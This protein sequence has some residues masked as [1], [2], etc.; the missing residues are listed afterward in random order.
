MNS[1]DKYDEE[2]I[3]D[4]I[5]L[6]NSYPVDQKTAELNKRL[7]EETDPIKQANILTEILMLKGV[8]Q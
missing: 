7:K 3:N 4:Y 5:K 6:I 1:K 8:K 2:E